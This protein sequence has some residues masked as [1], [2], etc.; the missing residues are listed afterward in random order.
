MG[1]FLKKRDRDPGRSSFFSV[2]FPFL[3]PV[4]CSGTPWNAWNT[5]LFR[6]FQS[7]KETFRNVPGKTETF[8]SRN[9]CSSS[10]PSKKKNFSMTIFFFSFL[11]GTFLPF[12]IFSVPVPVPQKKK[13]LWHYFFFN[14]NVPP[15]P[16]IFRSCSSSSKKNKIYDTILFFYG[17][18]CSKAGTAVPRAGTAFLDRNGFFG[19]NG[20]SDPV[21]IL[22]KK[23]DRDPRRSSQTGLR[24]SVPERNPFLA[25]PCPRLTMVRYS[26]GH[27]KSLTS[28]IKIPNVAFFLLHTG[29]LYI[30]VFALRKITG[31]GAYVVIIGAHMGG[32]LPPGNFFHDPPCQEFLAPPLAASGQKAPPRHFESWEFWG[33]M[34]D[35]D[36]TCQYGVKNHGQLRGSCIFHL[37]FTDHTVPCQPCEKTSGLSGLLHVVLTIT[38]L[39]QNPYLHVSAC[40]GLHISA[41]H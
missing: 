22:E 4:P 20:R 30:T 34:G 14:G 33:N 2:P 18:G 32:I 6:S 16:D 19:E 3:V 11:T 39:K 29:T 15:V 26:M 13:N 37:K 40:C 28:R 10:R 8:R 38:M 21:P 12:P 1:T 5:V 7:F 25:H 36:L 41:D 27:R 35:F 24:S 17:N 9:F 23:L 31:R